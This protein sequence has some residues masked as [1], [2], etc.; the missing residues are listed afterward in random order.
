MGS[1][2]NSVNGIEAEDE[3]LEQTWWKRRKKKNNQKLEEDEEQKFMLNI[4][5]RMTGAICMTLKNYLQCIAKKT[6][7]VRF[8]TL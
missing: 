8:M 2:E 4:D 5:I 6:F 3:E 1:D 7:N